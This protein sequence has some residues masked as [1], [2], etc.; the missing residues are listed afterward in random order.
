MK[1]DRKPLTLLIFV[2]LLSLAIA[3]ASDRRTSLSRMRSVT[4]PASA[5]LGEHAEPLIASSG[6][7]GFIAPVTGGSLISFSVTS[8]KILSSVAVGQT[9]GSISMLEAG[10]RR[11]VAVPAVNDPK[12]G[13]P[14]TVAIIDATSAKRPE[15][16]SLLLLP[17]D[18]MITPST[19]ARLTSDGRFCLIASSFDVPTLY[20]FDVETGQLLSHLTLIGRPSEMSVY[21]GQSRRLIAVASAPS[22]NLEV[23]NLDQEGR[24]ASVASFSPSIARLEEPNNPA[25]SA[26][27]RTLYIAASTGDRL[28]ALDAQSGI[29]IDSISIASPTRISVAPVPG[30]VEMI[31]ATRIRRPRD[32]K[33]G[34]VTIVANQD[35]RLVEESEFTPPESIEFS[36]ANNVAF[37][38]DATIAFVGSTS[39][40]LFAFNTE[41]GEL[42]SYHQLGSEI[43][44]VAL[45]ER[46]HAVAAVRASAS[47]DEIAIINFDV[48]GPD[49]GQES[50][51]S[52]EL[53]SPD[54][55]DQGRS[56]NLKLVISGKNF[57][58]G[59]AIV[60][61]GVE[62]GASL[63]RGGKALEVT[64]PK[65]LFGQAAPIKILVKGAN[66]TLSE[67]RELRVAR[68]DSPVIDRI[69]PSEVP[70]PGAP[71][72]LRVTG[73]NFRPSSTI[74][75]G[76][77]P[78][79]TRQIGSSVLEAVVPEDI[80]GAVRQDPIT[81]QVTD[82]SVPDLTSANQASLRIFGP[83]V[84]SLQPSV[85]RV[86]AGGKTFGLVIA[87]ENFRKGAEVELRLNDRVLK[88][89]DV[90][91]L[92][93]RAIYVVVPAQLI[94]ESGKLATTVR[95]PDGNRSQPIEL[96]VR[97]PEI[98]GFGRSRI[99]AGSSNVTFDVLGRN[100]RSGAR[101][102]AGNARVDNRHVRFRSSSRLTITLGE[103]L[104]RLLQ[105]PDALRI[106][107]VN[108]NDADG[109]PSTD[110]TIAVV[111]PR[112]T[113][114]TI[115][116][117]E[118]DE[119]KVR[120]VID[121]ANFRRG[122]TIEFF[123]VGMASAPIIQKKPATFS[124]TRL[125]V[126]M[127]AGTL[128]RI[129]NFSVRVVN[130][131]TVPVVSSFFEPRFGDLA[132]RDD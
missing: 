96:D 11:L 129:G 123:K 82:L 50:A 108:P 24:L 28:F 77:R 107:V 42:E 132:S 68:P 29:I 55:V 34:G 76:G 8:G 5:I 64:L 44:R 91:R 46:T 26:D 52:I 104:S 118:H 106:Q 130:P 51:P 113:D 35:G 83:R 6:K 111:G 92:S 81:V 43:R 19:T 32:E 58:D 36:A 112:I 102:Y 7:V 115:E 41:T 87:G 61:N 49:G 66:G 90:R 59:D 125:T 114:A 103:E 47:G 17:G 116:S 79:N 30:G 67:P 21:E 69:S 86:V 14:A 62:M 54:V 37:T 95:N 60:V 65:T 48:V 121:G 127:D 93:S 25:F 23:I 122:A 89:S 15:L 70:G 2:L 101:V 85:G 80:A 12:G 124:A 40:M 16:R 109:V 126:S 38:A 128:D 31:A 94:Q 18:A 13:I 4:L 1:P 88:V 110:K 10:G 20:S 120:V 117:I 45:S 27:G 57:T 63:A 9:L 97:A 84:T 39:G 3:Q 72:T 119:S 131:G 105:K 98:T 33:R 99:F 74:V 78:L 53:L 73:R 22:N 100:F 75:V 71:F 56:K